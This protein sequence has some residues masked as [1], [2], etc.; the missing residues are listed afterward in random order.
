MSSVGAVGS[1]NSI[2]TVQNTTLGK[3]EFFEMLIAQLKY[4]DPLNPMDGTDFTAQL[5]Q[6]SSLEQLQNI[7]TN[8]ETV[9]ANQ[10]LMNQV[11]AVNL[12]GK[13]VAAQGDI[14]ET[15][16][17]PKEIVYNLSEDV[18]SGTVSIYSS[19]GSLV[20]TIDVG[21]QQQGINS[22]MW[23]C[24]NVENGAYTFEI[25][26]SNASGDSVGVDKYVI[27]TVTGVTFQGGRSYVQI[28]DVEIP[29]EEV[30]LV[31][32]SE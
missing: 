13:D 27:G 10:I 1:S 8:L 30:L 19:D 11:E 20:E 12:I 3:D 25:E 29:F 21:P 23:D 4:Q 5:A 17:T 26:A 2:E 24:S 32:K 6:F 22:V 31:T 9:S 15:D 16:G 7:N 18:S 28:G 14:I